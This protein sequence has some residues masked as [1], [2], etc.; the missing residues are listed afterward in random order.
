MRRD[1]EDSIRF[2]K[3]IGLLV[4]LAL[5]CVGVHYAARKWFKPPYG[6]SRW[7]WYVDPILTAFMWWI[8]REC[9]ACGL[10]RIHKTNCSRGR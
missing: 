1:S 2:T 10:K 9:P 5:A 4:T 8:T 7:E 3:R 6:D